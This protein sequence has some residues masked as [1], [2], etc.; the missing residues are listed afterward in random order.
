[1]KVITWNVNSIRVRL[2]RCLAL[3]ERHQP[4]VLCLQETKV[5][6]DHFPR[7]AF[8]SAGWQVTAYGQKTYNGV[9]FL[10]KCEAHAVQRGFPEDDEGSQRR[11]LAATFDGIRIVNLYVPNGSSPDSDKFTQKMAWL[12][13]LLGWLREEENP[14]NSLLL[15]GDFNIAPEDRDT[16][17]PDLWRGK[18]LFHHDEHA[19]LAQLRDWGLQDTLRL[20]CEEGGIFSWWDYRAGAFARGLGMRIDLLLASEPLA[21]RH[22]ETTVDRD[23]RRKSFHKTKPSDHAPVV[24][25]FRPMG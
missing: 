16:H 22:I 19:R 2:E 9:A 12:D 11:M 15:C 14:S 20:N 17:D 7:E 23:E 1:M 24:A 6:D 13:R 8:E 18:V 5:D 21:A 10:S 3:L 4:D 25:T